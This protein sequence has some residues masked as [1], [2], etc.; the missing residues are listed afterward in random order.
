MLPLPKAPEDLKR[1]AWVLT[2]A[3][4][5][6]AWPL[7]T[8]S[9]HLFYSAPVV[10]TAWY[11]LQ[12]IIALSRYHDDFSWTRLN[13]WR[14]TLCVS[15]APCWPMPETRE[16]IFLQLWMLHGLP[17]SCV[18]W[19][20]IIT[21]LHHHHCNH[22]PQGMYAKSALL[23]MILVMNPTMRTRIPQIHMAI[24]GIF[25]KCVL[26]SWVIQME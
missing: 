7:R 12:W 13:S 17:S 10:L 11:A 14:K 19:P 22:Q 6:Q 21:Y 9:D 18:G 26:Q 24:V 4:L 20:T 2:S 23:C 8:T 15:L 5:S 3:D 25:M 1:W 16:R